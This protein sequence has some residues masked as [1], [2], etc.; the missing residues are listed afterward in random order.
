V[1][2]IVPDVFRVAMLPVPETVPEE[3]LQL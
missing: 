3:G 1:P 2:A